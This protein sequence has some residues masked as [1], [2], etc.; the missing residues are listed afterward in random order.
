[1][2]DETDVPE[3][4]VGMA[5]MPSALPETVTVKVI[6]AG[7]VHIRSCGVKDPGSIVSLPKAEADALQARDC[8]RP[9]TDEEAI[10]HATS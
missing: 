5:P 3:L 1:M 10:A 7:R 6:A 2:S 4:P 9:L 8:V